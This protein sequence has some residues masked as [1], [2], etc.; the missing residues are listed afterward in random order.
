MSSNKDSIDFKDLWKKQS[1]GQP[2]PKAVFAKLKQVKQSNMKKLIAS[3]VAL[4]ATSIVMIIVWFAFTPELIITKLG[5]IFMILAM[6]I[7]VF[8]ASKL[9]TS[10]KNVDSQKSNQGYL[11]NLV[12]IKAKEQRLQSKIM[13]LY[14]LLL[15][16][17]V[18]LFM[19][20]YTAM[21]PTYFGFLAYAL[22]FA[23]MAFSW[24]YMRPRIIKK[25]QAEV[26]G[27]IGQFENMQEQL[28]GE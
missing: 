4:I 10:Y 2:D 14:F 5:L 23:W 7:L 26:N 3:N 9:F 21:M 18:A 11:K 8:N 17:G 15:S 27:L 25:Q 16:I 24:F 28:N 13:S 22:T 20:E 19:Y 1:T 6:A 12:T